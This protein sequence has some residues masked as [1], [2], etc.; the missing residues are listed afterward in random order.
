MS[1][2]D[3]FCIEPG[4]SGGGGGG[5]GGGGTVDAILTLQCT[6]AYGGSIAQWQLAPFVWPNVVYY[7]YSS[8]LAKGASDLPL[9]LSPNGGHYPV[10]FEYDS[11]T[12]VTVTARR[13]DT[14][15]V[16]S[17]AATLVLDLNNYEGEILIGLDPGEAAS[18]HMHPSNA[19]VTYAYFRAFW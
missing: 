12:N 3:Q 17:D 14:N 19:T 13:R 10:R 9:I 4:D 5:G 8:S 6:F 16:W 2:G 11:D 18:I 15:G 1:R 7:P